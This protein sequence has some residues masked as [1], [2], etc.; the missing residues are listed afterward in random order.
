MH[1]LDLYRKTE[2]TTVAQTVVFFESDRGSKTLIEDRMMKLK[3]SIYNMKKD[4]RCADE[5]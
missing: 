1:L 5:C 2:K 4:Y 3:C